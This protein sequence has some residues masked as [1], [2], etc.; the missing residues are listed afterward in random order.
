MYEISKKQKII[1]AIILLI[2]I[3]AFLCYIY[4]KDDEMF[5]S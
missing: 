5:F 3:I 4:T 1:I 2:I